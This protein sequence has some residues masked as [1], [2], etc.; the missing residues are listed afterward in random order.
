MSAVRIPTTLVYGNGQAET[1]I[2]I[3]LFAIISLLA[4]FAVVVRYS[5]EPL[6]NFVK[7][8]RLENQHHSKAFFH[9]Q[10]G[11]YIASLMLSNALGS[12][13]MVINAEWASAKVVTEGT[14]CTAQGILSQIGDTGGAYFTG[15][16]AIHTF[17]TLVLRNKVPVWMCLA[18]TVFGWLVAV[19]LAATP[20]WIRPSRF[21]PVYG[22]N[23]LSC[24]LSIGH[25]SL[26][27]VLHIL[28]LLLGAI[29]SV[30][31]YTLVFLILRG[32]LTI[33]NGIKLNLNRSHR[34]S[35]SSAATVE[36]Q[37]FIS[38]IAR[39]MLWYPLAYNILLLP[40]IIVSLT[41]SSGIT[42]PF[43]ASVFAMTS[44]ALLGTANALILVNTLRILRPFIQSNLPAGPVSTE[45]M[46][47][48]DDMESF[49]AGSKSPMAFTPSP[50]TP[51]NPEKAFLAERDN[52]REWTPPVRTISKPAAQIGASVA[53][54]LSRVRRSV[55]LKRKQAQINPMVEVAHPITPVAELN[56]M[57][58]VPP[59]AARK[60]ALPASPRLP[61]ASPSL[62]VP[63]R[64]TR[65][66]LIRQ[67]TFTE[68]SP[69][70][71]LTTITLKTPE[72]PKRSESTKSSPDKASRHTS[73]NESLLSMYM[74]RTPEQPE[75]EKPAPPP[76]P[77]SAKPRP[78]PTPFSARPQATQT[79]FAT[80]PLSTLRSARAP[81]NYG[82]T[83]RTREAF[84]SN[85]WPDRVRG[86][87]SLPT[88]ATTK[89][90][91]RRSRSLDL[92]IPAY[93]ARTPVPGTTRTPMYGNTLDVQTPSQN[94]TGNTNA[95]TPTSARR[96]G[97]APMTPASRAGYL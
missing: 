19:L 48:D 74:S 43:P 89:A 94:R 34:W 70:P 53:R 68:G 32:T 63:R 11:A 38:A 52:K 59:P 67:P 23:D 75:M 27:V 1:L 96:M 9:T 12:V 2:A 33:K 56:A 90:E 81:V 24:G 61:G 18:T 49:F 91:R 30:V 17:N 82:M 69:E 84:T 37:R 8:R 60:T 6:V 77:M 50:K 64:T 86:D 45:K 76:K 14:L 66:P 31:F 26:A 71:P 35:T 39:S 3:V 92:T 4:I 97:M 93:S 36:Y 88:T 10:L 29:V 55:S 25:P 83:P 85:E 46:R 21:G 20:S 44:A 7:R 87:A 95:R 58:T 5:W 42:V 62:P 13:G 80:S 54:S 16:I 22:F 51:R 41:R 79:T 65:S 15:T 78:Q 73:A 28:P 57:I 72:P 47:K 40:E